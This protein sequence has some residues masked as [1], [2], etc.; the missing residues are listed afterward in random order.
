[1]VFFQDVGALDDDAQI[2][3]SPS[4]SRDQSHK[5]CSQSEMVITIWERRQ[6]ILDKLLREVRI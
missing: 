5:L 1:M 2:N 4:E 6:V 3:P